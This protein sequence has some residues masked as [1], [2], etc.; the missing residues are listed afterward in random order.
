MSIGAKIK[1]AYKLI[2]DIQR[3]YD[4][5]PGVSVPILNNAFDT[6]DSSD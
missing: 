1:F 2:T 3:D 4:T 6:V 5:W